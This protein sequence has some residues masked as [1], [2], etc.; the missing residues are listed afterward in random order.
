MKRAVLFLMIL[1]TLW[2]LCSCQAEEQT[3]TKV[4]D[5]RTVICIN[6]VT[7]ADLW[8]LPQTEE[9][10]KTTLWGTATLAKVGTGESRPALLPEPGDGGRYLFRMI[11]TEGFFYSANGVTLEA[12]WTL[13]IKGDDAPSVT[14]EIRDGVGTVRYTYE[15]CTARL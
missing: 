10:L 13:E 14:L 9:N 11:D 4:T 8:I 15:V 2:A 1:F 12:G 7:E 5:S 6:G 3:G